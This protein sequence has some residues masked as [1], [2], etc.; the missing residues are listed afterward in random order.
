MPDTGFHQT[1]VQLRANWLASPNLLIVS[2][3]LSSRQ[4]GANRW[5][6]LLGGDGNLIA[7][8]N[9]LQ[10]DL[11][12]VR[13]ERLSAGV[14]DRASATYSLNTQREERVNQGGNGNPNA[15]IGH[16]PERTTVHGVQFNARRQFPPRYSLLVGGDMYF[17]GL[18]SEAFDVNPVTGAISS[19]RPRVPD[20]ATYHQSGF[21]G[22]LSFDAVP[23]RLVLTGA[24]RVGFN[25]YAAKA[26]DAPGWTAARSGPTTRSTRL[27]RRS[28]WALR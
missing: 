13:V 19:R 20:G 24:A 18:T 12:Y 5:D 21:F 11:F 6:Q 27:P 15:T 14:F 26:S 22:Q 3:Y 9:D 17:E 8:L 28:A 25:V 10:L 4:D 7:E 2:N 16:E 23:D 1:G